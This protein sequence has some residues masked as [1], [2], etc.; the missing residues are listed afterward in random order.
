MLEQR[1][2]ERVAFCCGLQLTALPSGPTVPGRSFDISVCGVGITS[3]ILLNCGQTVRVRFHLHNGSNEWTD[4]D[5]LGRVAY[6]CA[7]EGENRMGIEFLETIQESTKPALAH[8][9]NA[10]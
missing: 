7:D 9:L 5:V 4:E 3:D 2:Y 10:L 1:R 8:K 6:S